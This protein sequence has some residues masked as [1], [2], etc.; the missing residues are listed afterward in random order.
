MNAAVST[1]RLSDEIWNPKHLYMF[2]HFYFYSTY[3]SDSFGT[4]GE[5]RGSGFE[6]YKKGHLIN[7]EDTNIHNC[8][9][10][11]APWLKPSSKYGTLHWKRKFQGLAFTS[12]PEMVV[13]TKATAKSAAEWLLPSTFE[14]LYW[15]TSSD[16]VLTVLISLKT[17]S[18]YWNDSNPHSSLSLRIVGR[19]CSILNRIVSNSRKEPKLSG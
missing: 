7:E 12:T 16:H 3:T 13:S 17:Q 14:A 15:K 18:P 19:H 4:V 5:M 1:Y 6:L 9:A 10:T 2:L 8:E 11:A